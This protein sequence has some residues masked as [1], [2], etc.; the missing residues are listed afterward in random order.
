MIY[1]SKNKYE[2]KM[3]K[4]KQQN[5]S[6]QRKKKLREEKMRYWPKFI[7][8]STSKLVLS[9]ALF[10]C[11]EVLV[12]CQY[13]IITTHDT[14][15]LYTMVAALFTFMGTVLGYY[16]KSTKENTKN[17]ITYETAMAQLQLSS[18]TNTS[19]VAVG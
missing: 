7:M 6:K 12:F 3:Q 16:M 11:I 2:A 9:L 17:G 15:S 8:P 10:L 5:I 13:M 18:S 14:N 1:M 4:I 19:E